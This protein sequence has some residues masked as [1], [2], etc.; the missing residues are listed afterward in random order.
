[1]PFQMQP[2]RH[3]EEEEELQIRHAGWAG[4]EHL[5]G[6]ETAP[7]TGPPAWRVTRAE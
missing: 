7:S 6:E 5:W 2:N 3:R 1:M 4:R